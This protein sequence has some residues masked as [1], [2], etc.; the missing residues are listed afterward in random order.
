MKRVKKSTND[1]KI[2]QLASELQIE[3]LHQNHRELSETLARYTQ[4]FDSSPI[5]YLT[6]GEQ[7]TVTELNLTLAEML[8]I[9]RADI[10]GRSFSSYIAEEDREIFFLNHR[11][12]LQEQIRR[13]C[14]VRLIS[15]AG[16][17]L[18]VR[19]D[20]LPPFTSGDDPACNIAVSDI[21]RLKELEGQVE[22]SSTEL[23]QAQ[24][25]LLN[26]EKIAAVGRV[27]ATII[28]DF[29]DPLQAISNVLGGIYR[30]GTLDSEDMPLVDLAFREARKLNK[31][32]KDLREFYQPIH[33]KT[34][35]FDV[36]IE[37][38]NI[39]NLN[40][41]RLSDKG[42]IIKTEFADN[43]P[44]I[45]VV[46]NQIEKVFQE[47]LDNIIVVCGHHDTIHISTYVDKN[48]LVVQID[49]SGCGI[50]QSVISPLFEPLHI[51]KSKK[52]ARG[53]GLATSYAIITMHG[54]T[55]ET[56]G[57]PGNSSVFK[58]MLPIHDSGKTGIEGMV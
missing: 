34:D 49:D 5:G 31:L 50:N 16:V 51:S 44:L 13:S 8:G 47:L 30:R 14:D 20:Y 32:V 2:S 18:A 52:P 19:L 22:R 17:I 12:Y 55:I 28:Q 6:I 38:E 27:S 43:I 3:K 7:F 54:G 33:G 26:S 25:R 58:L 41:P 48:T 9:Q 42:I 36:R 45:Q 15:R 4:L 57:A 23:E 56:E 46:A 39:I 35:L 10:L 53:S 29:N 1:S 40:R 24:R 21:S 37:L 11:Q